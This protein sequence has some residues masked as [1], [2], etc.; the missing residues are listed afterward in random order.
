MF[1]WSLIG[2]AKCSVMFLVDPSNHTSTPLF[3]EQVQNKKVVYFEIHIL[4][5]L[6]IWH[7]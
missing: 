2:L 6:I 1:F 5:L 4:K 3:V 7:L